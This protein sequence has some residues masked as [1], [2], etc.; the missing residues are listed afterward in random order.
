MIQALVALA[1][2]VPWVA[3]YFKS[4][5]TV[6]GTVVDKASE[7][8]NRIGGGST[9]QESITTILGDSVKLAQVNLEM[10]RLEVEWDQI[11][12]E[13]VQSAREMQVA[14]VQAGQKNYMSISMYILAVIVI[15]ALMWYVLKDDSINEFARGIITLGLGRFLGYLDGIYNFEFGTT[16]GSRAKDETIA[17]LSNGK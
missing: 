3:K 5:D 8:V 1:Q 16:R 7:V 14:L 10:K 4:S 12:L 11:Y 6:I 15:G 13:D 2:V 17:T 9:L